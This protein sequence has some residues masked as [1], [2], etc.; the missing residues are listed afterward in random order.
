MNKILRTQDKS[1]LIDSECRYYVVDE[2]LLYKFDKKKKGWMPS[3]KQSEYNKNRKTQFEVLRD[4]KLLLEA[5]IESINCRVFNV[6]IKYQK[7]ICR[8]LYNLVEKGKIPLIKILVYDK[9][10]PEKICRPFSE[11]GLGLTSFFSDLNF[12]CQTM[13][14]GKTKTPEEMTAPKRGFLKP[15]YEA[16]QAIIKRFKGCKRK[17]IKNIRFPY[18]SDKCI[19]L[20]ASQ[21]SL[22]KKNKRISIFPFGFKKSFSSKFSV[23]RR[24]Y[25]LSAQEENKILNFVNFENGGNLQIIKNKVIFHV[26][27]RFTNKWLYSPEDFLG[28][29]I[30]KSGNSF[31]TF[32]RE[33]SYLGVLTKVIMKSELDSEIQSLEEQLR[34]LNKIGFKTRGQ[35]KSIHKRLEKLYFPLVR[36]IADYCKKNKLCICIDN[37]KSGKK[38]GSF[39][40]DKIILL[41]VRLCEKE[42][43]PFVLV[44]TP[45][46]TQLCSIC[47]YVAGKIPLGVREFDCHKCNAHIY[48]DEN[49]AKNIENIGKSIWFDGLY[50]TYFKYLAYN[51]NILKYRN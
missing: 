31:L 1:G 14:N 13:Q 39:G 24:G 36:E 33:I 22:D 21:V 30:N 3:P 15:V 45:Y 25:K 49:A 12:P 26:M 35:V 32:S 9:S 44:P 47:N 19:R 6:I 4:V 42:R 7:K 50:E 17:D 11:G 10:F 8:S 29:D 18:P 43:I 28:F 41:L 20:H 16:S 46:T 2:D 23:Y 38:N 34:Q 27:A 5:S 40:Q 51:A 48:R 37:L